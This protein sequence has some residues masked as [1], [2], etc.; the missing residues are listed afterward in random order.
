LFDPPAFFGTSFPFSDMQD[1][2][3]IVVLVLRSVCRRVSREEL[4]AAWPGT[5]YGF[6]ALQRLVQPTPHNNPGAARP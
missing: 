5:D 3:I 1:D 2:S 4:R 6:A